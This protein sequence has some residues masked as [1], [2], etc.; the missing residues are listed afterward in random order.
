MD[1]R[2]ILVVILLQL[3]TPVLPDIPS[4]T[5]WAS[6]TPAPTSEVFNLDTA[7]EFLATATAVNQLNITTSDDQLY[8]DNRPILPSLNDSDTLTTM[9]YIRWFMSNG[10]A[11][12][13][14]SFSRI[15]DSLAI[16]LSGVM[17]FLVVL[18]VYS[19]IGVFMRIVVWIIY[20][21][22]QAIGMIT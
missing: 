9:G 7:E 19:V 10:S 5:A 15:I 8:L 16:L 3:N 20:K 2:I 18:T 22:M 14:G 4:P 1:P 6:P 13:F 21:I 11:S 17:V 12:L